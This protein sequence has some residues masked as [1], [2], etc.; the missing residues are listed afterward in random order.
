MKKVIFITGFVLTF[1]ACDH[2]DNLKLFNAL[3]S[4]QTGIRFTN[5]LTET[6]DWNIIEY[7]YFYNG[8]GVAIGDINNDGLPDLAFTANQQPNKLYVN[9]NDFGF[10]DVTEKA[11]FIGN[12]SKNTW[13]TGISM[14]DV[15]ADGWLDIYVC[16]V[17]KYKQIKGRNELFI[18]QKDGTFKEMAADYGLDFQGFSQQAAWLDYDQDGDIDMY[19]LNHSVHSP[20]SFTMADKRQKRDPMAG[21]VLFRND[22]GKFV[23]VSESAGIYGGAM[24]FG[25][26]ISVGDLDDNG[27]PDIY[28]SN[29]FH[30]NDYLYLNNGDGTF[31]ESIK[32]TMG[33]S[34][35]FSMGCDMADLNNDGG[36]D[37]LT[38]DMR[39][40]TEDI[41]KKSAGIDAHNLYFSKLDF[42]YL[43][44]Y[45]RNML[46]L[47]QGL[48]DSLPFFSEIA[49]MMGADLASTDWSWSPLIAD[50]DNDGNEDIFITNGI[51]KRPNDLDYL[52]FA[53]EQQQRRS[54]SNLQIIEKMPSGKV[55]NFAF[56][57]MG[58]FRPVFNQKPLKFSDQSES[59]GL[60][61][62]GCSNGAAYADLDNDG[63]LDLVVNNLNEEATIYEN[64]TE[65]S[66]NFIKI[67]IKGSEKNPFGIGAKVSIYENL[68]LSNTKELYPVRGWQSSMDY[69][70]HFGAKD[71][72][73]YDV[74]VT[75]ERKKISLEDI[76]LGE[77][78]TVDFKD[79]QSPTNLATIETEKPRQPLGNITAKSGLNF[80][81]KEN[82]FIDF[83]IEP[84]LPKMMSMEGPALA[85]GDVNNDGLE[86]VFIG[87]AKAQASVLFLQKEAY[88]FEQSIAFESDKMHEAID[89]TFFD[90]DKDGDL[91]LYVVSGGGESR[92]GS[93]FLEDLLYFNDGKGNFTKRENALPKIALNGSCVVSADFNEDGNLDLFIGSHSIPVSYGL[94]PESVV[95]INDGKGNF[96]KDEKF[97][98]QHGKLG[99]V[100]DAVFL[101]KE[102]Q[103]VIVGEWMSPVFLQV[104]KG[105]F[106]KI[107]PNINDA[108]GSKT[109]MSGFWNCIAKVYNEDSQ[110]T[111]LALG[112]MGTNSIL[113][114]TT[115]IELYVKDFDDNYQ[116]EPIIT[117]H[118]N[119][120]K[121]LLTTRD[122]LTNQLSFFRKKFL[123][124]QAFAE[125]SFEE[126][127]MEELLKDAVYKKV[128]ILE[129]IRLSP[130][131]D[132]SYFLEALDFDLQTF[133]IQDFAIDNGFLAVGNFYGYHPSIGKMDAG[134]GFGDLKF[135]DISIKGDARKVVLLRKQ[136]LIIVA[137][138]NGQTQV[139]RY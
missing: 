71:S 117:Y 6:E 1:L 16:H 20:E 89:A 96:S 37:I 98:K 79:F 134:G 130:K 74:V 126:I 35:T 104:K 83:N 38:V 87:G 50:F 109:A 49:P 95:L 122:N 52:K 103:L 107:N 34:S 123:T 92:E 14:A 65:V 135:K 102:K 106:E 72:T 112:N 138:N 121:E 132:G 8:G 15:N 81:H 4:S 53:D 2:K 25:L 127:F 85:S 56:K 29:D 55:E 97:A 120:K 44:Q 42:G 24:G 70:L 23:D 5:Q 22:N 119:G 116:T 114:N 27:Y 108:N 19:L 40:A 21:D 118:R 94:T 62:L 61:K 3:P 137:L 43:H 75:L 131:D 100:T 105:D 12:I 18:N 133:P 58:S 45:P 86:D 51:W 10:Q 36:L 77:T 41:L 80:T 57:N 69:T 90:A 9:Q 28:V 82:K 13:K 30:E 39:P 47:N 26:G 136:N 48:I 93:K 110:K 63:D 73:Q 78:I 76:K 99:M 67:K 17:G 128:E 88:Q 129:N 125:A 115:P 66:D 11:N 139:F 60:N 124:Y 91:D 113:A 111:D 32:E 7:L 68:N 59:W 84:L 54:A 64:T 31:T 33:H 101:E 46:H